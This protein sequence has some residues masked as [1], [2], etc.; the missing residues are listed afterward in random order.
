MISSAFTGDVKRLECD[1]DHSSLSSVKVR[2]EWNYTSA[3][4]YTFL[5]WT[6]KPLQLLFYLCLWSSGTWQN[7]VWLTYAGILEE[8]VAFISKFGETLKMEAACASKMLEPTNQTTQCHIPESYIL[9]LTVIR[10]TSLVTKNN[11]TII[12]KYRRIWIWP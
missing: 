2:I 5:A 9:V 4:L 11:L 6:G 12:N 1:V 7:A 3:S 10:T 8:S